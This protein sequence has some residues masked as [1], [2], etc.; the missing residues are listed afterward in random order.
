M[1]IYNSE[2]L[3]LS[4]QGFIAYL[5]I[6]VVILFVMWCYG[7]YLKHKEKIKKAAEEIENG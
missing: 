1:N 7:T 4:P 3:Q 5:L 2:I 6:G